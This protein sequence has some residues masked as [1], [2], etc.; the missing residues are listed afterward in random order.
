MNINN[1]NNAGFVQNIQNTQGPNRNAAMREA[2]APA[3]QNAKIQDEVKFSAKSLEMS[4]AAK[5]TTS[6]SSVRFDLV[7]RIKSEIAAGTY[8]TADKFDISLD[9][10]IGRLTATT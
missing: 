4:D 2:A 1:T 7:N 9:R 5:N 3:P 6:N 10:L 8:D